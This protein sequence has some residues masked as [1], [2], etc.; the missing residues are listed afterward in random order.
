MEVKEGPLEKAN[1]AVPG[2]AGEGEESGKGREGKGRDGTG[3]LL[4]KCAL[5]PPS[6]GF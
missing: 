3:V 1:G 5:G 2:R 4:K 6:P